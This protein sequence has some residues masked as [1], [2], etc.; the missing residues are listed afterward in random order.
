LGLGVLQSLASAFNTGSPLTIDPS[1]LP[2]ART[3]RTPALLTPAS[4]DSTIETTFIDDDSTTDEG[5]EWTAVAATK[6]MADP[7]KGTKRKRFPER[8]EEWKQRQKEKIKRKKA[9]RA[10]MKKLLVEEEQD[11]Q[12]DDVGSKSSEDESEDN[13]G[14]KPLTSG[15]I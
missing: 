6:R 3:A 7:R 15:I 10:M 11:N 14:D 9:K 12:K 5:E 2:P 1:L 8:L 13:G 4:D